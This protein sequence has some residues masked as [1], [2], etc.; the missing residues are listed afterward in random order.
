MMSGITDH[1]CISDVSFADDH[2]SGDD[3]SDDYISDGS[4]G[5]TYQ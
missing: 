5:D 1:C 3:I 2:V 4:I